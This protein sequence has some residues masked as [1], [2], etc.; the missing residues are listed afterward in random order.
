MENLRRVFSFILVTAIF[1]CAALG[2]DTGPHFDLTRAVLSERGFADDAVKVAQL[3]NWLTD[4]YSTTPT[5][6][7]SRREV[8]Q[9]CIAT[10]YIL[11]RS[12]E[13]LA[14]AG[15]QHQDRNSK[16]R[17]K[18][19]PAEGPYDPR[20]RAS[21]HSGFLLPF[22][23]GRNT[24]PLSDGAYRTET[25]SPSMPTRL[26]PETSTIFTGKYPTDR[27]SG[28]GTDPIPPNTPIHGDYE[29]GMN[30]DSLI[31]PHWDEAY[32]FAYVASHEL[33]EAIAKWA[34]DA[35]PG[36]WQRVQ[37]YAA[38]ADGRKKL[39]YDITALRA[40]SMWLNGN[41]ADGHWKG[42][43]SGSSR[44]FS[45]FSFKWVP[46][47]SSVFVK[48]MKNGTVP[49]ALSANLYENIIPPQMPQMPKFSLRRRAIV[50]R[51]TLVRQMTDG[52]S[53]P[54]PHNTP[55]SHTTIRKQKI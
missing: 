13:L 42:N 18:E 2:F 17:Q 7:I 32:V 28:P 21:H 39:D 37:N 38:D 36:F 9:S 16:C 35:S 41:G 1:S 6:D 15:K 12:D 52:G 4:Y 14:M 11:Q 8:L 45:A 47:V 23:L 31:R 48:Q 10:I 46:S 3:E 33:V 43:K 24:S 40:M 26:S 29:K 44:F 19:R 53:S 55:H 22:E 20:S 49:D 5:I 34:D 54:T 25:Y 51:T 30:K 50:I 27:S